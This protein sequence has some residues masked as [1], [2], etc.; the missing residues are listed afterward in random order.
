MMKLEARLQRVKKRV[1]ENVEVLIIDSFLK[2]FSHKR[3]KI[4][5]IIGSRDGWIK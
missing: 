2:E 4:Y 1:R 5:G 3:E